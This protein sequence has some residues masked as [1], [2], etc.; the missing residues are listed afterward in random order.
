MK[1]EITDEAD[2]DIG[3]MDGSQRKRFDK[4][5]LKIAAMPP[6]RHFK[7]HYIEQVRD[8]G[9]IIYQIDR[10]NEVVYILRCFKDHKDYDR[11]CD[12]F[13]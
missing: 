4:H 8:Q 11:W 9:R 12:S 1:I 13:R 6:S 2:E 10:E 5:I 7:D 3:S